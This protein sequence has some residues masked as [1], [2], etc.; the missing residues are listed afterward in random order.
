MYAIQLKQDWGVNFSYHMHTLEGCP[1]IKDKQ[2]A[3]PTL[4]DV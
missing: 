1:I 2:I 3:K 4:K